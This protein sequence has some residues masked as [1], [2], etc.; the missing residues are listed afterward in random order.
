MMIRKKYLIK[1]VDSR[2]YR[3]NYINEVYS[4]LKEFGLGKNDISVLMGK[5]KDMIKNDPSYVFHY[6]SKYWSDYIIEASGIN[7]QL[8]IV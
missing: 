4:S 6:N 1:E 7:K 8:M 5:F 3:E 2:K